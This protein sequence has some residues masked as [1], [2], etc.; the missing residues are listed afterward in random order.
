MKYKL[1]NKSE[2]LNCEICSENLSRN[3]A[4]IDIKVFYVDG[5]IVIHHSCST[6]IVDL[7]NRIELEYK[8][9]QEKVI[10]I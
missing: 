4:V 1:E 6:H 5:T 8:E 9:K 7:Y 3:T 2:L 10:A